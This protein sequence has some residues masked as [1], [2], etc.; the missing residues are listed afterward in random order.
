MTLVRE[1][2]V[3]AAA[4][5]IGVSDTRPWRVVQFYVAQALSKMNLG[6]VKAMALDET[7]FK[8][9]GHNY[10][11]IPGKGKGYLGLLCRFLRKHGG[12]H[13]NIAEVVCDMSPAFLAAIGEKIPGANVTVDWFHA[14]QLFTTA[15]DEVQK[16]EAKKHKL[17]KATRW[18]VPKAADGGRL[19]EK[20][21]QILT[22]LETGGFAI[23]TAWRL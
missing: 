5:I 13:N 7:A 20:Q 15:V 21:Q 19:T 18:T 2:P 4:R 8:R 6:G 9:G 22:E 17:P 10:F 3:L 14:V 23:A 16:T 11:V 1:M 12:D